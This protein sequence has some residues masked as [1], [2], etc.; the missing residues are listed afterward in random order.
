MADQ[1]TNYQCPNCGGPLAFDSET[2]QLKCEYCDSLFTPHEVEA[3]YKEANEQALEADSDNWEKESGQWTEEEAE[4]LRA[5]SCPSC[6]ARLICDEHTAATS[7]PYCGNN[8]I[9]PA[10]FD[11]S[12]R[13][14][15]VLPFKLKKEEAVNRLQQFYKGKTFLPKAFSSQNHIEEIKG[16]YVPFWLYDATVGADMTYRASRSMTHREGDY[17]VT[18]TSHFQVARKGTVT[19]ERVP[20]DASS[21]MPDEYMDAVEPFNYDDLVPFQMAY[22]AGYYADRYDVNAEEDQKRANTRMINST[23]SAIDGTVSGY[24]SIVPQRKN[25]RLLSGTATYAFLPVWVLSTKWGGKNWLFVMNG[26]TGKMIG[27]LPVDNGR[28]MMYFVGIAGGLFAAL[29][30]LLSFAM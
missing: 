14:E 12:L 23:M 16:V 22:M 26:Q 7:C 24:S 2:Q 19:F 8:T 11:G 30:F 5:Y 3:Y 4:H 21:K 17:Q 20:V 28:F 29:Y 10:Q 1:V 6:G 18:T 13:P 25:I 27:D 9:V 15:Y